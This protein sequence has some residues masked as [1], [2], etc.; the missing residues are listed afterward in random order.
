MTKAIG[1]LFP[2]GVSPW[3][4]AG[5]GDGMYLASVVHF[6]EAYVIVGPSTM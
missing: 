2:Q 3:L 1:S 5:T 4:L 6:G